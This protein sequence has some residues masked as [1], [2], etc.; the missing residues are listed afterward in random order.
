MEQQETGCIDRLQRIAA[1]RFQGQP[2]RGKQSLQ[3]KDESVRNEDES[4]RGQD[5]SVRNEDESVRGQNESVRQQKSLRGKTL[6]IEPE[7]MR[8]Q[9]KVESRLAPFLFL[10]S[11][12]QS[13]MSISSG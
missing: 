6:V 5:E 9:S 8:R 13:A 11:L 3:R 4:V 12:H 7:E 10:P 2:V 1:K